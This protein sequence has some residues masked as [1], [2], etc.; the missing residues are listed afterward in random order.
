MAMT[1]V[2]KIVRHTKAG[3]QYIRYKV[4]YRDSANNRRFKSFLK[5]KDAKNFSDNIGGDVSRGLHIADSQTVVFSDFT[6]AYLRACTAQQIEKSTWLD[7]DGIIRNYLMPEFANQLLTDISVKNVKDFFFKIKSETE[8]SHK[9]ILRIK[10]VFGAILSLAI[11]DELLSKNV[12][13]L[14]KLKAPKQLVAVGDDDEDESSGAFIP[15]L[16]DLKKIITKGKLSLRDNAIIMTAV[17]TG[18]RSS[19]LFGLGWRHINFKSKILNVR[20]RIDFLGEFG[21]PK[22][23]SSRR[24]IPIPNALL[25]L[26]KEWKLSC[27]KSDAGLCFPNNVGKPMDRKNWDSR[28]WSKHLFS[29]GLAKKK[30]G[31]KDS[32]DKKYLFRHMRHA[33]ASLAIKQNANP[34]IIMKAMGHTQISVTYDL[35]GDLFPDDDNFKDV[36]NAIEKELLES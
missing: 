12:A 24:E 14:V 36:A 33:Y 2:N 27:P 26:L 18:L 13:K 16:A 30:E 7:Y 8:L 1:T 28:V 15:T 3:E 34:K 23:K 20:R 29:L 10:V 19:E 31:K 4:E 5:Q 6:E 22:T 17:L 21:P 11:E 35:Y 25:L 32:F 9:R